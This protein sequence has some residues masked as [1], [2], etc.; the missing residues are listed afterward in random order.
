MRLVT[1]G[2]RSPAYENVSNVVQTGFVADA[3]RWDLL[4]G[5]V[6]LVNPS[7]H[8]SLSLVLLESWTVSIPV[9]VHAHCD[10]TTEHVRASHGGI[11]VD[12]AT[13]EH[14]A[15]TIAQCF[16]SESDRRAMG[17]RGAAYAAASCSWDRVLDAYE[18]VARAARASEPS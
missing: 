18:R 1:A 8:E 11:A 3:A 12:F 5:A 9:I 17:A 15:A 7:V 2:E 13:S 4:R 16:R 10:V 14:A 6:A